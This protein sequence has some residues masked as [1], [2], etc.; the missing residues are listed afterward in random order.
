MRTIHGLDWDAG[1]STK[2]EKHG[3]KRAE[4]EAT[5]LSPDLT[6]Q[7]DPIHSA[8]E[9]RF[10]A[11]ARTASGRY[12]FVVFTFRQRQGLTLIRPIGARYM[13]AKEIARYE[14]ANPGLRH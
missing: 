11:I 6:A 7:P 13:H 8:S 5:L 14:Q 9:N 3:V 10:R 12:I 4:I 1:N 2:C